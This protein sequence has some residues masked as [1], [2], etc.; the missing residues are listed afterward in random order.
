MNLKKTDKIIVIVGVIILV[1]A[2]VGIVLYTSEGNKTPTKP[3]KEMKKYSVGWIDESGELP[4]DITGF[5]SKKEP[6]TGQFT[7]EAPEPGSVIT[8]VDVQVLWE[9]DVVTKFALFRKGEDTLTATINSSTGES[10]THS[11]TGSGNETLS[12][13][14][15]S[16][17]NDEIIEDVESISEAES[18]ILEKY[19]GMNT[20]SFDYEVKV[21]VGEKLLNLRPIKLLKYFKDKGNDFTFKVTYTYYH[22][23]IQEYGTSSSS[24]EEGSNQES[25][26]GT[27]TYNTMAYPGK[28]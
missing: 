18:I 27:L 14:V 25:Y 12:F 15:Y 4:S 26:M 28:N 22:P 19:D 20:V 8:S 13:S 7:V 1:V 2:A 10:K 3:Q 16:K 24:S 9:D 17:P 23:D 5:A 21:V 11:E 6:F